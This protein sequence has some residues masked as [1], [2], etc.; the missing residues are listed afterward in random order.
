MLDSDKAV[1][2]DPNILTITIPVSIHRRDYEGATDSQ[3]STLL[4]NLSDSL[5]DSFIDALYDKLEAKGWIRG[6]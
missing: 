4:Q 3:W 5:R 1:R 2:E 6:V